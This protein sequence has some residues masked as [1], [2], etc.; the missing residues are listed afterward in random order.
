MKDFY[1]EIC[2]VLAKN[3]S[4]FQPDNFDRTIK[5]LGLLRRMIILF[6][7]LVFWFGV[8]LK[9]ELSALIVSRRNFYFVNLQ[10]FGNT[11]NL[12]CD[13]ESRRKYIELLAYKMLGF[14]KVRLSLNE[15]GFWTARAAVT[16]YRRPEKLA[17][18]FRKGYLELYDLTK[19]GYDLKL[20]FVQNG[21]YVG[22]ILEQYNYHDFVSVNKGDIVIDAGGCWGDTALYF[23]ARG[24]S[25]VLV[26]EFIPSNVAIFRRNM[27]MNP[28]HAGRVCLLENAVWESSGLALSFKDNGPAS[29][30]AEAGIYGETTRTLSIDDLV[31]ERGLARVDFIKMDIEGAELPALKGAAE[32]IRRHKPKLAISAYHQPDDLIRIPAYILSLNPDYE[33]YLDYY[34]IVGDE[35]ILYAV[36]RNVKYFVPNR[37]VCL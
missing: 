4:N 37:P 13:E 17:A 29:R 7:G 14:T 23:A 18:D 6:E 8:L 15:P 35:I 12:L 20:Y 9:R 21:I 26:Y 10:E 24:A 5:S 32:T 19:A 22:F 30:V 2:R 16:N 27:S 3:I 1:Q 11:F 25:Q 36:D 34:T 33:I 31:I 28:Q